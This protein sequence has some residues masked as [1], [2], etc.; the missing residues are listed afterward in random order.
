MEPRQQLRNGTSI[1]VDDKKYS[2]E[3]SIIAKT[4]SLKMP[5]KIH[6]REVQARGSVRNDSVLV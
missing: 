2:H 1:I 6:L 5:N 4:P 3:S